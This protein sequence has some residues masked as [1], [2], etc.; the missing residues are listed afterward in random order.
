MAKAKEQL[1]LPDTI[2]PLILTVANIT[3]PAGNNKFYEITFY[4]SARFYKLMLTNK[5]CK[6]ALLML[7]QSKKAGNPVLVILTEKYGDI[8]DDVKRQ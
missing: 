3:A 2:P 7:K 1:T 8:I 5:N 6:Q 4:Q